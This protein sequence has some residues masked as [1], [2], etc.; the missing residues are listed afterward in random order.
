[1]SAKTG[2]IT[3][4]GKNV[5]LPVKSGT[6]GP[7]VLD[8]GAQ[9]AWGVIAEG[10][11][12]LSDLIDRRLTIGTLGGITPEEVQRIA[13]IAAPLLGIDASMAAQAEV[14]RRS[15]LRALWA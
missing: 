1:M 7:D 13:R 5:Q 15:A 6:I 9:V 10:A 3:L 8:I 2:S 12:T 14:A 4:D 11:R